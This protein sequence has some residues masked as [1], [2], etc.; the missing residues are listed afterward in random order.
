MANTS[1]I[2]TDFFEGME[3]VVKREEMLARYTSLRI[4]GPAEVLALPLTVEG[5]RLLL[6]RA[7]REGVPVFLLGQG[8]NVLAPDEG[9]RG[10]VV[11][12]RRGFEQIELLPAGRIGGW[13]LRAGAGV[14]L[15][16]LV[17]FSAER[18]IEG[19]EFADGIPG[20]VGGAVAMNAGTGHGEMAEVVEAVRILER[21]GEIR[22]LERK[23]IPFSYRSSRLPAGSVVLEAVFGL[24][25]GEPAQIRRRL[26]EYQEY[27][28][29]T[30]PLASLNAGSI[31]KNPTGA[32]AGAL[33]DRAGLKG[34]R[35]GGAQVSERHANFIVN[36]GGATASDVL[37]L[38][39]E[40]VDGVRVHA[41][42]DLEAEIRLLADQRVL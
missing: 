19:L 24:Q 18:G 16:K 27:R 5:L 11:S 2:S 42:V 38:M 21:E 30:Q 8:S 39:A 3:V 35:R 4:G 17:R 32:S 20:S 1:Q 34:R 41:G 15:Q 37:G 31:F 10:I 6:A 26:Q 40:I 29:R 13:R 33:I 9:V 22:L 25:S 28:R 12:L 14:K 36:R 7:R 23:E